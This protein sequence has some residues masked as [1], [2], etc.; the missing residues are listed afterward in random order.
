MRLLNELKPDGFLYQPYYCE[1]NIW[2]LCQHDGFKQS[3][4]IFISNAKKSFTMLNQRAAKAPYLPVFWDYHVVLLVEEKSNYIVDFD[5]TLSFCSDLD[6][7]LSQSFLRHSLLDP[8]VLPLFK[9]IPSDV[10]KTH[11]SSDRSHMKTDEGWYAPPPDWGRIG[12]EGSN[13][14]DFIDM[15]NN[16]FGDV[17]TCDA[18]KNRFD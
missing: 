14:S 8:D 13:L 12:D 3:F 17:L 9:V 2:Q 4:V 16:E 10:Y 15:N 7:Y 1:E 5:T 6:F 11:F 18:M